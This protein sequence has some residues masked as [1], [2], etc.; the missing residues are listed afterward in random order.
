MSAI[1][2]VPELLRGQASRIPDQPFVLW[3][4][5]TVSYGEFDART[6]ALAAGLA[7]L[8]VR[9]RDVVSVMLPNCLSSWRRGRR[10]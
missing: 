8:G 4:G 1:H 7:D 2:T 10:S 6:D 5:Q 3:R 9:P